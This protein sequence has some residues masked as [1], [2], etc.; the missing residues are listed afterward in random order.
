MTIRNLYLNGTTVSR[1]LP[2][3]ERSYS[4]VVGQSGKFLLD[5]EINQS[6][7]LS[8]DHSLALRLKELPS[9]FLRAGARRDPRADYT[10]FV[11][12]AVD[13]TADAFKLPKMC[14]LVADCPPLTI[15]YVNTDTVG[16]NVI[17]LNAPPAFGGPAPNVQRT[18][19]VF[20]EVFKVLV[21]PS[22][23]ATGSI[24]FDAQPSDGD[25]VTIGGVNLTARVGVP[26]IDEFQIGG[27]IPDTILNAATAIN[28]GGNSFTTI[29]TATSDGA[30]TVRLRA[31]TPGA[32]GNLITLVSSV[33]AV[34]VVSGPNLTGGADTANKPAQDKIYRHGNVNSPSAVWLDDEM[35]D[36]IIGRET[37]QRIQVQYR[38]RVTGQSEAIDF[39]TQPEGFSNINV[40]AQGSQGS[41]V[42]NY[43][44]VP[45]D[46]STISLN[47]DATAYGLEDGGLWISGDG[48]ET[49]ANDL[50]TVDGFVYAIPICFVHRLNDAFNGGAGAGFEPLTNTNGGL[51]TTH[52]GF[53]HPILGPI[54][55]T[56]S[57][58]P[59]GLFV[60]AIDINNILDLRRHSVLPGTDFSSE[61]E[62][63]IQSLMDGT[64]QTWSIDTASK[65]TM[66]GGTGY[67]STNPLI[68]NQIG[69]QALHGGTGI[70]DGN[71]NRG[72]TIRSFDHAAR[73]FADHSTVERLVL[74]LIPSYDQGSFPGKYVVQDQAAFAGWHE[75][76]VLHIDLDALTA[77]TDHTY[78]PPGSFIGGLAEFIFD[79]AP[80]GTQISNILSVKH[81]EGD[82]T[83]GVPVD[84]TTQISGI[85]GLGT[86]HVEITLD[87]NTTPVD[88]GNPLNPL[89]PIVGTGGVDN[90][91]QRSILVE[92]EITYPRENV[93]ALGA[94]TTD[95]PSDELVP[96]ATPYPT[97]PV[98]E[99][100][101]ASR[102]P[103]WEQL[104][105]VK[106]RDGYREVRLEY[107]ASFDGAGTPITESV[108][109]TDQNTIV[110]SK[111]IF[112]DP[113]FPI[114]VTDVPSAGAIPVDIA[115]TEYGSSSR[116]LK[117]GAA[118]PAP[119]RLCSV[120][121]F[122]QEPIPQSGGAGAGYQLGVYFRSI[123]PQTAGVS[124]L[125]PT[126]VLPSSLDV[127]VLSVSSNVWTS[128]VGSAG[129][130]RPFPYSAPMDQIPVNPG[131]GTFA[132]EWEFSATADISVSDFNASVGMLSLQPHV[133][134]DTTEA[135][136]IE[137]P[138]KDAEF[139][140]YF[141]DL[142]VD[143]YHPTIMAKGMSGVVPHK[144]WVPALVRSK[145]DTL[146][147]R[148]N[149]VLLMVIS[150]W[151]E[152]D[153]D[154]IVRFVD[155][156]NTTCAAFYRTKSQLIMSE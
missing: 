23:S 122:A 117:L 91:S 83:S 93:N 95:T 54:G 89:N 82:S 146:V 88:G 127:E 16:E 11:P 101:P 141:P 69:R 22:P 79:F 77:S 4:W 68:C 130:E 47:S 39:K 72:V 49:A 25:F 147:F 126:V 154:N 90:G 15:E 121:Y 67:V 153:S 30:S 42:A 62:Y 35:E 61:I 120:T 10:T 46:L 94:G 31:A 24:R 65:Q 111:R 86:G 138:T 78:L 58:R 148:K 21:A 123:A 100:N 128:Q 28:D 2:T 109:S 1:Y 71:T 60:D 132:G 13:F 36:P 53:V 124:D 113:S 144:V 14:A 44:F 114:V 41:P 102:P 108:V 51:P 5:A 105:P 84:V 76:D 45:A 133:M 96:S 118:L 74:E 59:D 125:A 43:P 143:S 156:D 38:I 119:N 57:D 63:Q 106:F 97:G 152:M 142:P 8:S 150:R 116:V 9:G 107:V 7:Q 75:G 56:E 37:A 104:T 134:M 73:T 131:A 110:L 50:G 33:P 64:L 115:S 34:M 81:N 52:G 87:G 70:Q 80:P 137:S 112:G 149:E 19:F 151:A 40:L 29:V 129:V 6:Q 85:I 17:V 145:E 18:D 48:S 3:G 139:R 12:F 26:G 20:L 103:D 32:A 99:N 98:I 136:T 140:I 155:S 66:G 27:T 55:A 92:M 135:L